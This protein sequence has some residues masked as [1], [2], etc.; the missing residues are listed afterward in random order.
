VRPD[1]PVARALEAMAAG[2]RPQPDP[3]GRALAR[4]RRTNR[5]WRALLGLC[6]AAVLSAG[7]AVAVAPNFADPT[8]PAPQTDS[9]RAFAAYNTWI[10]RLVDSP[11]RGAV[12]ADAGYVADFAQRVDAHIRAGQYRSDPISL[13]EVRVVFVDDVGPNRVAH[14]IFV[15]T[16]PDERKWPYASGWFVAPRGASA[17]DLAAPVDFPQFGHGAEP[18]AR[19]ADG[20]SEV[21]VAPAGCEVASA[22]LPDAEWK[23]EP[24]GSY[25]VRTEAQRRAERWQVTCDGEVRERVATSRGGPLAEL[26]EEQLDE[27]LSR[28]RSEVDRNR[29]RTALHRAVAWAGGT[30]R[31]T[32]YLL[33]SG[34]LTGT[35]TVQ[36]RNFDGPVTVLAAPAI[37]GGWIGEVYLT[38]DQPNTEG[39][40]GR[41]AAF[42]VREDPTAPGAMLVVVLDE[43]GSDLL[44]VPPTGTAAV[45]T[46]RDGREIAR[47]D[48]VAGGALLRARRA[49]GLVVEALDAT[50][51]VT[52]RAEP[53]EVGWRTGEF[54]RWD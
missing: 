10:Q 30:A 9:D 48:V 52:C 50:G 43:S 54:S 12:G 7:G 53:A 13:R 19:W 20:V 3:Y 33:W 28:A 34:E 22:P 32:P 18:F 44:V 16:E 38:L 8:P 14:A 39:S 23:P 47:A 2:L 29:A 11:T 42:T 45:R 15:L 17:A 27:A 21:G 51:A 1:E 46:V 37:D 25:I 6:V 26:S 31:S 24:T 40:I 5:R 49:A 41:G 4:Y 36:D 35:E